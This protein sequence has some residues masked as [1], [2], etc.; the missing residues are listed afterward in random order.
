MSSRL[1]F[2]IWYF[3][4]TFFGLQ[5]VNI[6]CECIY[7]RHEP[8]T[9]YVVQTT[10]YNYTVLY[11]IFYLIQTK[12]YT[13]SKSPGEHVRMRNYINN[14]SIPTQNIGALSDWELEISLPEVDSFSFVCYLFALF[15]WVLVWQ[16]NFLSQLLIFFFYWK[17]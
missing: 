12:I 16:T 7:H 5:Y 3:I 14:K 6:I 9:I 4:T 2:Y 11:I 13:S 8:S 17:R 10:W 15:L 1:M